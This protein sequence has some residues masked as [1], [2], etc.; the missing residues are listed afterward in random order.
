MLDPKDFANQVIDSCSSTNDLCRVL[1]EKAYPH[2][3]W[4]S[5]RMQE[6]GR[7]RQG[8]NWES[9]KG[10]LFLSILIRPPSGFQQLSWSS[11][12]SAIGVHQEL[13]NQFPT[14]EVKIKWPNDIYVNNAKL[15]GILCEGVGNSSAMFLIVG[16]GLNVS[17]SPKD[18]TQMTVSLSEILAEKVLVDLLREGIIRSV[19]E[20][21]KKL[22]LESPGFIAKYYQKHSQITPGMKIEWEGNSGSVIGL[23]PS[24]ELLVRGTNEEVTSLYAEDVKIQP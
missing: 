6:R 12:G 4:V 1:G 14:L 7:G 16:I 5:S 21:F 2:G 11:L 3:S 20:C 22:F 19:L 8:R 17:Q 18:F 15:G 10:N 9:M 13:K 24:G 23:G